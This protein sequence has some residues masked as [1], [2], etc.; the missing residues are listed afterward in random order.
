MKLMGITMRP[1]HILSRSYRDQDHQGVKKGGSMYSTCRGNDDEDILQ[2]AL[3]PHME[4]M[5]C[6]FVRGA[7]VVVSMAVIRGTFWSCRTRRR[8]VRM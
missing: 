4:N 7:P 3:S 5:K 1:A 6:Y 8:K 2:A